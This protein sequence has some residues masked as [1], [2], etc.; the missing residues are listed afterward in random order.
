M[1]IMALVPGHY[2]HSI[3]TEAE[4]GEHS[5]IHAYADALDGLLSPTASSLIEQQ[6]ETLRKATEQI[7][8]VMGYA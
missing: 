5:A 3:V 7:R 8:S 2:E 4:R 6:H 1:K